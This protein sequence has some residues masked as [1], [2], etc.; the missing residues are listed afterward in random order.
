[1]SRAARLVIL[2]VALLLW[3]VLDA[4]AQEGRAQRGVSIGTRVRVYAPD[5][6]EDRYIGRIDSLGTEVMVLDTAGMRT[7]LGFDMGPVLVDEFRRVAIRLSAIQSLEVSTGRTKSASTMRGAVVGALI[8]GVI[9]G[10]GNLP[11]V[12]PSASDFL[13][14]APAGLLV[15]GLIGGTIGWGLGGESWRPAAIPRR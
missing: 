14:G 9:F 5:L 7:R 13:R 15:G 11:E 3:P 2:P 1:M 6:R 4:L 8:G 12:N 10:L